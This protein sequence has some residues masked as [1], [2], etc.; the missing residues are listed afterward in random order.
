MKT[1]LFLFAMAAAV[2]LSACKG[3]DGDL[4]PQGPAGSNGT[5]GT[6]GNADVR[7][8]TL[9]PISFSSSTITFFTL[10]SSVTENM[11][12]SSMVLMWH[13]FNTNCGTNWYPVPGLGCSGLYMSRFWTLGSTYPVMM[14]IEITN[15]NGSLY[16]GSPVTFDK[17]KIIIAPANGYS[18]SIAPNPNDFQSTLEFYNLS[19]SE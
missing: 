13:Q 1:K 8:Y 16:T 7:L 15:P 3:D 17:V 14:G 12:D 2:I 18:G 10:D 4:G 11:I 5:N 19:S 6:N 9:G